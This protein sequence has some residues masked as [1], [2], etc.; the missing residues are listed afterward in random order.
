MNEEATQEQKTTG[1]LENLLRKHPSLRRHPHPIFAHFP[2]AFM[3]GAAFFAF[4]FAVSGVKSFESTTIDLI[5]VGTLA[6]IFAMASGFFTW[7]L[8]YGARPMVSIVIKIT[9]SILLLMDGIV[10][11]VWKLLNP[12]ILFNLRTSPSTD[13]WIF[14]VLTL[15]LFPLAMILGYVGGNITFPVKKDKR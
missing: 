9:T 7:W 13:N 15:L 4:L 14:F 5:A 1:F 8:N 2:I 6:S 11:F 10:L 12:N 3:M